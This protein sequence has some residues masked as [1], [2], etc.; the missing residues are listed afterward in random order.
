[1]SYA[2]V[3]FDKG[4]GAEVARLLLSL[5]RDKRDVVSQGPR[6]YYLVPDYLADAYAKATA[7]KPRKTRAKKEEDD[8]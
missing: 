8:Q 4:Q 6:T 1:M 2:E 5:A 7:P 3:H